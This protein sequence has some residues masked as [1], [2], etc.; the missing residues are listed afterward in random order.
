MFQAPIHQG[1]ISSVSFLF[2]LIR[3]YE[4]YEVNVD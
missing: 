2:A 3:I 4:V 1:T